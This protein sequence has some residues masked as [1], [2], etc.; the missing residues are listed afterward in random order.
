MR[1]YSFLIPT[2]VAI[3]VYKDAASLRE[4]G[5]R[6]TP[7]AWAA[8]TWLLLLI[9]LP[10]YLVLRWTVWRDQIRE[11]MLDSFPADENEASLTPG[12]VP[13]KMDDLE[14][15]ALD[16]APGTTD[17]QPARKHS[18]R[19]VASLIIFVLI[20]VVAVVPIV[21]AILDEE[22]IPDNS[23]AEILVGVTL[24]FALVGWLVGATLGYAGLTQR[25]RKRWLAGTGLALNAL[26]ILGLAVLVIVGLFMM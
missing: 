19:G 16:V 1:G 12:E 17:W 15:R 21:I 26:A 3:A 13:S 14:S 7:G 6:L 23:P 25:K 9:V 2:L 5:A 20:A 22:A 10:I 11:A 8:L 18:G 4:R 24:I